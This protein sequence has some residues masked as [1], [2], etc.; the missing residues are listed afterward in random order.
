MTEATTGIDTFEGGVAV[1]TGAASGIGRALADRFAAEGM[2]VAIADIE[3]DALDGARDE[4][5]ASGAEVIAQVVDVSDRSAVGDFAATVLDRFGAPTVLC[6]NA[7]VAGA[8][9]GAV[10]TTTE[11]DWKWVLGVNLMGVVH[12]VQA[13][14]PAMVEA[15]RPAHVV[16][17]SS[18]YGLAS[19]GPAIYGVSKHAVTRFTEALA[20]DLHA[21]GVPIG[22]SVLCPGLIATRIVTSVRNR[23]AH[24][25]NENDPMARAGAGA[26][27][28]AA[29]GAEQF[30]KAAEQRFMENGMPPSEVASIVV[31]A[32]KNKR[33]YVLTHPDLMSIVEHRF[34]AVRDGNQP[35]G[36]QP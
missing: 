11:N 28:G 21:A 14:V 29:G 36:R 13:F 23:P 35:A 5:E 7:G 19:Q 33:F 25:R 17:T 3:Q 2:K 9:G 15:A 10:W 20:H 34:A 31:D 30:M 26:G 6:N 32:I 18:I 4:L 22:A 8:G 24:L 16:N 12:G 27:R 1:V